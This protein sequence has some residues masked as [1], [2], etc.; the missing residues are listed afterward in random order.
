VGGLRPSYTPWTP[1]AIR[2]CKEMREEEQ[3]FKV[4]LQVLSRSELTSAF[5]QHWDD[6][7]IKYPRWVARPSVVR[8]AARM[9]I[10]RK[11]SLPGPYFMGGHAGSVAPQ[12]LVRYL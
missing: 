12:I 5:V 7:D 4:A 6:K 1:N 9:F 11:M 8:E 2:R 3:D 10:R